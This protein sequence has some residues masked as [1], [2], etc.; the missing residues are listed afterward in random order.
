MKEY[1][2]AESYKRLLIFLK[3]YTKRLVISVICMAM[4]GLSNVVVPWLI[5]DVIDKVLANK[6]VY[7]LNLIVIGILILFVLRGIF[8]FGQTYLLSFVG[9]KIVID[10]REK[11]YRHLQ[12][13]SL[14]YYDKHKTGVIMSNLTMTCQPC[15]PLLQA[16]SF[17]SFRNLS[18]S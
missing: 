5:K 17:P 12:R 9:Q 13:L 18:S 7:T 1:G 8:F 15:R 4:S 6:D 2:S 11:L 16:T 14:S 3:P 10:I